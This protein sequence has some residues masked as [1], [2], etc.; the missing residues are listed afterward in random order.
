M[1]VK[2][3]VSVPL[4]RSTLPAGQLTFLFTDVQGS[5]RMFQ[6][7]GPRYVEALQAHRQILREAL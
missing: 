4:Q 5:T 2:Q 3:S 7:L 1:E 6:L